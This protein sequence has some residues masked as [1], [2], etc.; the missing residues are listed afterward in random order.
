MELA[1]AFYHEAV[2]PLVGD[3]P[4]AA[5]LIGTGSDVLGF[6]TARSTDQAGARGCGVRDAA[7]VEAVAGAVDAGCPTRSA[8]G[9]CATAGSGPGPA[10]RDGDDA[11]QVAG[12]AARRGRHPAARGRRLARDTAAA[13]PR[14]VW[15]RGL[16]R[17]HRR[18]R[19]C[20]RSSPGTRTRSSFPAVSQGA[21]V[22]GAV[23]AV[24]DRGVCVDRGWGARRGAGQVGR[25]IRR[26]RAAGF[27]VRREVRRARAGGK[28]GCAVVRHSCNAVTARGL[29]WRDRNA[30]RRRAVGCE[31]VASRAGRRGGRAR[32]GPG[33]GDAACVELV[34]AGLEGGACWPRPQAMPISASRCSGRPVRLIAAARGCRGLIARRRE[35]GRRVEVLGGGEALDR[36]RVRGER[37]G[38]DDRDPR[39]GRQDLP[40]A[41]V[42][43]AARAGRRRRRC[44]PAARS[45]RSRSRASRSG[46]QLARRGAAARQPF[47]RSAQNVGGRVAQAAA[48]ARLQRARHGR[49]PRTRPRRPTP[50]GR[51]ACPAPARGRARPAPRGPARAR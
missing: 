11:P 14:S 1:G 5:A 40:G 20:A 34:A 38:A 21:V 26:R 28:L 46:A 25:L 7:D 35:P 47:Q 31:A 17:R 4:H 16:R 27:R 8:T 18:A 23:A 10:P 9:P 6:D 15:R 3:V 36:Q 19:A 2:A 32:R 37:G 30:D 39:Q 42:E 44:R 33:C 13:P 43:Q 24:G 51:S 48:G 49:G 41:G 50:P 22:V 12:R 29:A 45:K